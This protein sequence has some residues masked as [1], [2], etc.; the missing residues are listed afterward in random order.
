M[1]AKKSMLEMRTIVIMVRFSLVP[2]FRGSRPTKRPYNDA[3]K[4]CAKNTKRSSD[5]ASHETLCRPLLPSGPGGVEQRLVAQDLTSVLGNEFK[6]NTPVIHNFRFMRFGEQQC[7]PGEPRPGD[8]KKS[9]FPTMNLQLSRCVELR[10][11]EL[12]TSS[13]RTKRSPS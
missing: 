10:R 2:T 5:P 8:R 11:I 7:P 9:A 13:L 6:Q 12:P 1:V 4:R 3:P